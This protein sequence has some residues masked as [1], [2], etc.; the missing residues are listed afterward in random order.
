M[1]LTISSLN[2]IIM[3]NIPAQSENY[4]NHHVKYYGRAVSGVKHSGLY[5]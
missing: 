4:E 2:L 1:Y 3:T 5:F